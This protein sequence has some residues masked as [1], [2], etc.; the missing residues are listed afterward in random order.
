VDLGTSDLNGALAQGLVSVDGVILTNPPK[1][2]SISGADAATV[3]Q[4][5]LFHIGLGPNPSKVSDSGFLGARLFKSG[6]KL[7]ETGMAPAG[8]QRYYTTKA[9]LNGHGAAQDGPGFFYETEV[10]VAPRSVKVYARVEGKMLT[11]LGLT[12]PV[13]KTIGGGLTTDGEQET[14]CVRG[15]KAPVQAEDA[16]IKA[17]QDKAAKE[18]AEKEAAEKEKADKDKPQDPPPPPAAEAMPAE[19]VHPPR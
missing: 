8:F 14:L 6:Q 11:H 18:K 19:A 3:Y 13:L 1:T 2:A 17:E 9:F 10:G 7:E 5:D 12:I 16:R 15:L 4:L